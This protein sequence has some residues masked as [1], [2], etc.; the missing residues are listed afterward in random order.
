MLNT[1]KEY[2][3]TERKKKGVEIKFQPKSYSIHEIAE[4]LTPAVTPR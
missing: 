3:I 1:Q 2:L 4:L